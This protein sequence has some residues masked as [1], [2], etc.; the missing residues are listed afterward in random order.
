MSCARHNRVEPLRFEY[1]FN[2]GVVAAWPSTL[3]VTLR[4]TFKLSMQQSVLSKS[5]P[6][7]VHQGFLPVE[8]PVEPRSLSA[9]SP[10]DQVQIQALTPRITPLDQRCSG[11]VVMSVW[12]A[13]SSVT[14]PVPQTTSPVGQRVSATWPWVGSYS[15]PVGISACTKDISASANVLKTTLSAALYAAIPA[16]TASVVMNA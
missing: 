4:T 13:A 6:R 16:S 5:I 8:E 12:R 11:S 10:V 7:A 1:H 9:A 14:A 15:I 2:H 3:L